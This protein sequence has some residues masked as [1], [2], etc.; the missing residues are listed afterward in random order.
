M[1]PIEILLLFIT[2]VFVVMVVLVPILMSIIRPNRIPDHL[3]NYM[4][5][6]KLKTMLIVGGVF[7]IIIIGIWLF[8]FY[9]GLL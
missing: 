6:T 8:A 9:T 7:L 5:S 4:N 1:K 2:L 3:R